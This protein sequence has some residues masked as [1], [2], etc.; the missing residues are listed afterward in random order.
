MNKKWILV[1]IGIFILL[2]LLFLLADSQN[3]GGLFRT[4]TPTLT[5][6]ATPTNT[7]TPTFTPTNTSTPTF[8]FTPTATQTPTFTPTNTPV[9]PTQKPIGNDDGNNNGGGE[10]SCPPGFSGTP[11][12]CYLDGND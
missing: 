1:I 2:F 6:T 3:L 4:P 11:P 9:P 8:T 7:S 12:D 10:E 5:N